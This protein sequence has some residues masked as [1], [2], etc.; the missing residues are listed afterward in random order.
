MVL[1]RTAPHGKGTR[2]LVD[3]KVRKTFELDPKKFVLGDEWQA[4]IADVTQTVA[5]RLGL[6]A[7]R[8][9]SR[10]YKR[11]STGGQQ[12]RSVPSGAARRS[13]CHRCSP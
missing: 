4:A 8:L 11:R 2:T 9:E 13:S 10:L 6:P 5:E 3:T 1:C 7:D 12:Q